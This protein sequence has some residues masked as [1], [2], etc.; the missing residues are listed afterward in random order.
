MPNRDEESTGKAVSRSRAKRKKDEQVIVLSTGVKLKCKQIPEWLIVDLLNELN[1][2]RPEIPKVTLTSGAEVENPDSEAY[3]EAERDWTA[4]MGIAFGD[5]MI[6]EGTE[7]HSVPKTIK[8]HDDP[9]W[10]A[11]MTALKRP[12]EN[13]Y[14]RYLMWIKYVAAPDTDADMTKIM[15]EVGRLSG[16]REEDVD[17]TVDSFRDK[18]T[19]STDQ[20]D[21][22]D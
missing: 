21:E 9:D 17:Q 16:V 8:G 11:R 5:A 15:T 14:S 20:D 1:E 19:Q 3:E 18:G 6:V 13:P 10:I 4:R 22:T 2:S 12:I 7:T